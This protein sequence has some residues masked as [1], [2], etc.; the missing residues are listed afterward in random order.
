MIT[1]QAPG[2][3][4]KTLFPDA[5]TKTFNYSF[6]I[7]IPGKDIYPLH[8]GESNKVYCRLLPDLIPLMFHKVPN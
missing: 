6:N 3:H 5:K 2:M 7:A 1:H 4:V 8:S